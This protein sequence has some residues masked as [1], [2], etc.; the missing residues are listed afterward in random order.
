MSL[1]GTPRPSPLTTPLVYRYT[2]YLRTL[3]STVP[4]Y[5]T[6]SHSENQAG[7]PSTRAIDHISLR[8]RRNELVALVGPSGCG[9]TTLLLAIGGRIK[10]KSGRCALAE[11][12]S[13]KRPLQ[14]AQLTAALW[15]ELTLQEHLRRAAQLSG[16]LAVRCDEKDERDA[17]SIVGRLGRAIGVRADELEL[18]VGDATASTRAKLAVLLGIVSSSALLLLDDPCRKMDPIAVHRFWHTVRTLVRGE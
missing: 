2:V 4:E 18:R 5:N 7:Q 14:C 11:S 13:S 15:P 9:K 1:W 10:A 16:L 17:R 8:V 12:A 3:T 6:L